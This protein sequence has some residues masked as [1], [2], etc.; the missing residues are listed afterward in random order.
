M[1]W[2]DVELSTGLSSVTTDQIMNYTAFL[3]E[4]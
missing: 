3:K 2:E 4:G 1:G